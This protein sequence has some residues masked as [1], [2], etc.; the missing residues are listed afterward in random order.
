[1][2][3]LFTII[4]GAVVGGLARLLIP[5]KDPAGPVL[6]ILLGIA[7]AVLAGAVGQALGWYRTGEGPGLIAS[8]I[9][10]MGVVALYRAIV[11]RWG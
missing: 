10:A 9:G 2:S 6:T 3:I 1:M 11:M 5:G 7:G 8:I 4:L